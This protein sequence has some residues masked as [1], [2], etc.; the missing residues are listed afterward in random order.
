[1]ALRMRVTRHS[2]GE[3]LLN[4]SA[5]AE[6]AEWLGGS[7]PPGMIPTQ[8]IYTGPPRLVARAVRSSVDA[9]ESVP[10]SVVVLASELPSS[11]ELMHRQM[12]VGD[13]QTTVMQRTGGVGTVYD[14]EFAVSQ[15]GDGEYFIL[16]L[17]QG[18]ELRWPEC[19][20]AEVAR[21]TCATQTVIVV[22]D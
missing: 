18:V 12:G 14:A 4:E 22:A 19:H 13:W 15:H 21:Q 6:L 9:A 3:N 10:V 16:A 5:T 2:Y 11:V 8:V 17:V 20:Q 1:M 7:L